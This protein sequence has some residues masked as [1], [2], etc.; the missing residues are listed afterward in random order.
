MALSN[1]NAAYDLCETLYGVVPDEDTFE[2]LALEAWSRIGTKHTR[3]YRY[4][5]DVKDHKLEL[6]CNVDVIESVHIPLPDAQ[7]TSNKSNHAWSSNIW[8]EGYID[9]WKFDPNPYWEKGKLIKYDEGDGVLYFSRNYPRV[10]VVYHGILADD[11]DGLPLVNDK[12]LRAIASFCAYTSIYKEAIKK[13]DGNLIKLAQIIKEDWL[14]N[15][16]A[17]RTPEHLSQNDMD[18]ILDASTRWDRKSYGRSYKPMV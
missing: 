17:A 5:G 9:H 7:V 2:D 8:V 4:I 15:C 12:E 16:N 3:L 13:K 18:A 6:P 11:E 10:K 1:I 14:R